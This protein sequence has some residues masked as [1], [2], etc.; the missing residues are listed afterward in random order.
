MEKRS[1]VLHG[2][3]GGKHYTRMKIQPI[4]YIMAN[5]LPFA[6]GNVVKYISRHRFKNG[7]EDVEKVIH[8]CKLILSLEYKY[9]DEQ[10][11]NL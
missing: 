3:V 6:D 1:D 5:N 9:S 4:E 10:I 11:K 8:Y 2:E 7:A